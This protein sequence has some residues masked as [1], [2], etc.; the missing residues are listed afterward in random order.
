MIIK[1][2]QPATRALLCIQPVTSFASLIRDGAHVESSLR[3]G[4]FPALSA[5][6][7]QANNTSNNNNRRSNNDNSDPAPGYSKQH[8]ITYVDSPSELANAATQSDSSQL[9]YAPSSA[10]IAHT[11]TIEPVHQVVPARQGLQLG[12]R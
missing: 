1:G 12:Q 4:N 9:D 2:A 8:T 3:S 7:R 11:A 10:H 5:L 6:A